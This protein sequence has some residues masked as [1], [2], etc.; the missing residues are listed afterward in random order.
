MSWVWPITKNHNLGK[1]NI[2]G[3]ISITITMPIYCWVPPPISID[4][5]FKK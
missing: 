2:V 4:E 5:F 1:P 3:P